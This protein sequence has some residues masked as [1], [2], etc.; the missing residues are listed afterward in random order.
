VTAQE[1]FVSPHGK[2]VSGNH[3][4]PVTIGARMARLSS[5][6]RF[7]LRMDIVQRNPAEHVRR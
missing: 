5:F 3:P 2:G 4:S 6:F 7:L 1:V